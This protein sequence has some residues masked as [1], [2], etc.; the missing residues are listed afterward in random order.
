MGRPRVLMSVSWTRLTLQIA[1]AVLFPQQCVL[2]QAWV[3]NPE[4]SPLCREC[5]EELA[6]DRLPICH[7][8]GIP[9]PGELTRE[10]GCCTQCRRTPPPF[11]WARGWGWFEGDL[12]RLVHA[13]KF[14]GSR[15]LAHPLSGL[16]AEVLQRAAEPPPEWVVAVPCHP[17]RRRRRGFDQARLLAD[18]LAR[19]LGV[20]LFRGVRR[21][22]PTRPQPGLGRTERR[23]NL[24]DAFGLRG[25]KR[26][27]ERRVLVVD[28]VMTSGATVEELSA[29]L[30][31]AGC[32]SI[33]VAVVARARRFTRDG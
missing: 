1:G 21:T 2:C 4:W 17:Q 29:L 30:R 23:R 9:V 6:P 33:G 12:R 24:R 15:R 10:S 8:C 19:R 13:F 27:R 5:R 16:L 31:E 7:Y 26:L 20:P 18:S 11:D 14:G 22:R 32:R 3:A 28:D 25:A